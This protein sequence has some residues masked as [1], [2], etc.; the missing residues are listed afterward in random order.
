VVE[1]QPCQNTGRN[2]RKSGILYC[3]SL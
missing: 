1:A 2:R 3:Q